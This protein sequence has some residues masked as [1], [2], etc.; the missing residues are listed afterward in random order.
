[1]NFYGVNVLV[2]YKENVD[3]VMSVLSKLIGVCDVNL[4]A[5]K[6]RSLV[7]GLE[8]LIV[9]LFGIKHHFRLS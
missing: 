2:G 7:F 5:S 4:C 3:G 6:D 9:L 1:M 8:R